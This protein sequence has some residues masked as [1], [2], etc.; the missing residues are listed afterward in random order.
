MNFMKQDCVERMGIKEHKIRLIGSE[1]NDSSTSIWLRVTATICNKDKSYMRNLC[2]LIVPKITAGLTPSK[3]FDVSSSELSNVKLVDKN[4]NIPEHA[5]ML[6]GA[7]VFYELLRPGQM[8]IQNS[9]FI[10]T[11]TVF[12][13]IVGEIV[14][15][16]HENKIHC[17]FI[18]KRK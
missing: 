7:K 10:L 9:N 16:E 2:F 11:N 6:L 14:Q 12:G 5:D 3:K 8:S 1:L 17:G 4:F 13:F 15:R 18:K